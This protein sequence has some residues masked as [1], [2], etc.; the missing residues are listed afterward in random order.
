VSVPARTIIDAA[1]RPLWQRTR[2]GEGGLIGMATWVAAW[3]SRDVA[4]TLAVFGLTAI[5]LTALYLFNDV[6]DRTIDAYNPK[7]V[8]QHRQPLLER[9][10]L[11]RNIALGVH[12]VTCVAAWALL[13]AWAAI[14][15]MS[16][17][18]L[19][20]FY[21]WIGKRVPGLDVLLVGA[22]GGAVVGLATRSPKLLLLAAAMTGVSHAFQLQVDVDAD[23]AAGVC[24]SATTSARVRTV[25]W[26]AVVL[27]VAVAI[28]VQLGLPWALSAVIPCLLLTRGNRPGTDWNWARVYFAVVWIAAAL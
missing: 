4:T 8:P 17:L 18:V 3:Q 23:R 1:I 5:L 21:S 26:I 12:G 13:G 16:L 15:T 24:N 25:V 28:Y 7:K 20:P 2:L 14:C 10:G 27:W 22:M 19:N 11:F 6:S 9:P